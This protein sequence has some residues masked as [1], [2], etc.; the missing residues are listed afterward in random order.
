[1]IENVN[2]NETVSGLKPQVNVSLPTPGRMWLIFGCAALAVIQSSLGDSGTSA[3]V[4][5]CAVCAAVLA[6]LLIT[7]KA[8]GFSKIA[9]GSAAASAMVFSLLL[10]NQIHPVY[11][12]LGAVFAMVVVKHSFGGLG[13]N[14]LNPALGG[15][16][17]VRFSW[18]QVYSSAL[19][20]SPLRV[21]GE[22]AHNSGEVL[23]APMTMISKLMSAHTEVTPLAAS[24]SAFLNKTVFSLSGSELPA[25]YLD[26]LFSRSP[27]IIADRGLLA[28]LA[29]TI[30]ITAFKITRSW[31]PLAYTAFFGLLVYVFGDLPFEGVLFKGD[32]LF[33][34][35][36]G[37]TIAAAF[38]LMPDPA[39]GA[40]SQ[41][42]ILAAALCAAFLTWL[43]R[44][45]HFEIYGAF[46]AVALVNA[47]TPLLRLLEGR[48]FYSRK[49]K[50]Q[51]GAA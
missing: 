18:P 34:L 50:T 29:G 47:F 17:F 11:A 9:D 3:I 36:S 2:E 46:F 20:D 51:G 31:I 30:I 6:E 7:Y 13:S 28:L 38:I 37:G 25:E 15:F 10:P 8:H 43:F 48:F 32:L 4:A 26:L 49:I 23:E 42:G 5:A 14:W 22:L 41:I 21:I 40:R 33:S 27:G 35:F 12:V 16:L 19:A 45:C 24:V 44:Y 39:S 1:M